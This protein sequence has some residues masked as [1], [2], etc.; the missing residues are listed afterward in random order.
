M[1]TVIAEY[2][3]I[4]NEES[5]KAA[6]DYLDFF[7]KTCGL[8]IA[9]KGLIRNAANV[10]KHAYDAKQEKLAKKEAAA[11]RKAEKELLKNFAFSEAEA[12]RRFDIPA[13]DLENKRW[14]DAEI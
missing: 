9:E 14:Y 3:R 8:S 4:F 13:Y 1:Q 2:N 5:V 10:I 12:N 6:Q 11:K 7:F